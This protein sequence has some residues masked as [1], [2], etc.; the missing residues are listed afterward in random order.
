MFLPSQDVDKVLS[1]HNAMPMSSQEMF[2]NSSLPPLV[3]NAM[4]D[5]NTHL[6]PPELSLLGQPS[7]QQSCYD[8]VLPF[9]YIGVNMNPMAWLSDP[10]G[11]PFRPP[12]LVHPS[13]LKSE[14]KTS[15]AGT[16]IQCL[17]LACMLSVYDIPTPPLCCE[18]LV[19]STSRSHGRDAAAC[20][21]YGQ[22]DARIRIFSCC[23]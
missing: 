11:A 13:L 1:Q 17:R 10:M 12:H 7:Q 14:H 23:C 9:N 5:Q 21:H 22:A 18:N 2:C 16:G 20:P 15:R 4:L 3:D 8:N 19:H 6:S